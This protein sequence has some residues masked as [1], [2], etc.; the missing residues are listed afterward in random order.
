MLKAVTHTVLFSRRQP[1]ESSQVDPELGHQGNKLGGMGSVFAVQV[2][3]D[4]LDHHRVFDASDDLYGFPSGE[5]SCAPPRFV[6]SPR[7]GRL[8]AKL[9][10][11]AV[12]AFSKILD[13]S[14][15]SRHC[16]RSAEYRQ[17]L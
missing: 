6:C 1:L 10:F 15:V 2:G 12:V 4:L 8:F 16:Q 14:R 17:V 9:K 3:E 5:C 11:L 7:A 13:S